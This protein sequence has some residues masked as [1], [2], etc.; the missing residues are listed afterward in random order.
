MKQQHQ[1]FQTTI[2]KNISLQYLLYTPKNYHSSEK[3]L[4]LV[5]F[6]HGIGE[7]GTD[8]ELVKLFGIPKEIENGVEFP[9]LVVSP[10]CP[11]DTIWAN[12]LDAL[13]ALLGHIIET[14]R[15]DTSRIYLTGL[16]MGGN[17]AWHLAASYPS[18]FA[19]VVPICGWANTLIGF[20]ERIKVLRDVPVWVFHGEKDEIV[21]LKGSQELVDVLKANQGNVKF[22]V[23]PNTDHDSW[24][25]TYANPELYEWLLQQR[26]VSGPRE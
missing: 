7:R 25:Q 2:Q 19:A 21:P 9:F 13:H 11:E 23:Y 5:L 14:Y 1:S 22:T 16:S 20:P 26:T 4:P 10:Q 12:E 18:M 24:T 3:D 17:G 8:L 15:V 6:L